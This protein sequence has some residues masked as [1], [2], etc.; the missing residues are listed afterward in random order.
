MT[1]PSKTRA[2]GPPEGVDNLAGQ[3]KSTAYTSGTAVRLSS[4]LRQ[5]INWSTAVS[6]EGRTSMRI[7]VSFVNRRNCSLRFAAGF[8]IRPVLIDQRD[9][10]RGGRLTRCLACL[11]C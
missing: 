6:G 2:K 3:I 7:P 5:T 10:Y 1:A 4:S 9:G 11:S 8:V